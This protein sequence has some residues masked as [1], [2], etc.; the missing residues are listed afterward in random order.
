MVSIEIGGIMSMR[1]TVLYRLVN[2]EEFA[3]G[4][5]CRKCPPS[6]LVELF[7]SDNSDGDDTQGL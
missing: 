3:E 5:L 1:Y 7:R 4:E 2:V 6:T